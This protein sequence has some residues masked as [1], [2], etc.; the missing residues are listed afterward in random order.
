MPQPTKGARLGGSPAHERLMLAN[1]ATSLFTHGRIRTTQAK[2]RRVRP[3]AEKLITKARRG[4]LASRREVMR[5]IRDTSVV[6]T[7]F[8]EIGPRYD[9]RPGGYT[10]ITKLEPRKGDNAPMAMI[11][12][13]E[14]ATVAQEAVGEAERARSTRFRRPATASRRSAA[15]VTAEAATPQDGAAEQVGAAGT[16][17]VGTAVVDAPVAGQVVEP[18]VVQPDVVQPDVV[19]PDVLERDV[20][21]PEVVEPEV[22]EPEVVQ[23]EVVQPEVVAAVAVDATGDGSADAAAVAV[24]STGDGEADV[25][26]AAAD[27]EEPGEVDVVV[28]AV[29][30]EGIAVAGATVGTDATAPA[31]AARADVARP[32]AL[33]PEPGDDERGS[34]DARA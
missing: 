33:A 8:T 12:L 14:A 7:L 3:L 21:E 25:V 9:T 2:A 17:V 27:G 24:D 10:R 23:P 22:V 4:D 6:H 5:T 30:D 13:V 26:V 34:G 29:D 15:P 31:D 28:T 16:E 1:L 11:E 20:V 18:D 32:D 19:Q